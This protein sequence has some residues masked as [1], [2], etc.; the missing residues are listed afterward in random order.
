M[1]ALLA[2]AW[3]LAVSLRLAYLQLI[4]HRDYVARA[5]RQQ[6]RVVEISPRRGVIYDRNG[7]EL[8]MSLQVASTFA[9]PAEVVHPR[10]AAR[11]LAGALQ[12]PAEEIEAK[13][14]SGR[15]F[16]WIARKLDRERTERVRALNLKGI[17]F[18]NEYR[19]YYPK[20][21]LA[22]HVLG[23]VDTDEKGL[24]GVEYVFD[25]AV[26]GQP[27]RMLVLADA[28]RRWYDRAEQAPPPG[29]SLV[30][31]L[32]ENIQYI[33]ERELLRALR[34]ARARAGTI[35]VQNPNTGEVLALAG[36]PSFNP[37]APAES[38]AEHRM[39]RAVSALFEPGSTFKVVTLAA[40][41]EERL[42]RPQE[43]IDCQMG[44]IYIGGHRIRD[45]KAF[46]LL[47]VAEVLAH[48]SDVGAIKLGLRLGAAKLSAY[49]QAFGFGQLTGIE[50]PGETRGL[51]RRLESWTPVSVG[52]ISMGQEVGVTALQMASAMSAIA[53]G[54]R[55]VRPRIVR[56]LRRGGQVISRADPEPSRPISPVTAATLRR[57]LEGVV[58][59]GTGKSARLHGYTAGGKTG[60]AQKI[61]P[62]TGRYSPTDHIASFLGFAPLNNPSITVLVLM[63]SPA[64][65]Y[66]GGVVAAPVFKRVAEQVLNYLR[67]P[68][69]L[70]VEPG[71]QLAGNRPRPYALDDVR[72]FDPVQVISTAAA[73]P[74]AASRGPAAWK[75]PDA[76]ATVVPGEEATVLVPSLLGKTVRGVIEDCLRLGIEPVLIGT[77]VAVQ[78][79]P[80]VGER[81]RR[82]TRITVRFAASL[83]P[84]AR[85]ERGN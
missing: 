8:A 24:A 42:T 17:Y 4:S 32:D 15:S 55:L 73:E 13:L 41:L 31:T 7:R 75:P 35:V 68:H 76:S 6:E 56:E 9:I 36:W 53:N 46:G 16:V 1:V 61:D 69:D 25:D 51:L 81:I 3:L 77:G 33:A 27:G 52:S 67:V 45:H 54:G 57:L 2:A 18:Q 21:S 66:H 44:A 63:D 39:N 37:N 60:T 38:P 48:S 22:A 71:V 83:P 65:E 40:A 47:S 82:G 85:S 26:R 50:L 43:R 58:L 20:G 14:R 79:T 19:R 80:E 49:I 10:L 78:Q 59:E 72:D 11:L 29:A 74:T 62:A 70:P 28:R 12:V 23:F 84:A 30:L 5:R 34:D 64:G